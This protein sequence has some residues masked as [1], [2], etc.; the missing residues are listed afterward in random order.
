VGFATSKVLACASDAFHVIMASRSHEKAKAAMSEIEAAG[1]KGALS[2]VQLDVTD[3]KSIEEAAAHVQQQFGRLDVLV[4]NAAVGGLDLDIRTRFQLCL[5]TNVT[6]PA[7]VAAAFRPLLLKSQNPYS[8]YVGSGARTL[9]RNATQ[10]PPTHD[11]IRNGY[12]YQVSKAALNMLAVLE[13]RDFGPNGLKVFVMSPG[14]VRSNLRGPSEEAR[15]GWGQAGDPEVSGE[16][17]LSIVQGNRDTDVG[18]LV[19]KDGVYPW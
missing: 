4:N 2:T 11:N 14:F 16:I 19:H 5:E 15:S 7:M 6:G 18:C 10:K 3:D 13:A 9:V 8:I 1:I 12:A 17:V